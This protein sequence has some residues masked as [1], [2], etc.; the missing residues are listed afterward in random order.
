MR[1]KHPTEVAAKLGVPVFV[2][3]VL[4]SPSAT[5]GPYGLI[6]T[7]FARG[8]VNSAS[9]LPWLKGVFSLLPA[10]ASL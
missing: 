3:P 4:R 10:C 8:T 7:L 1:R 9:L 6:G 5:D 2:H